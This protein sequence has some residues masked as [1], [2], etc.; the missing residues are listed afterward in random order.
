MLKLELLSHF[1]AYYNV[2][3]CPRIEGKMFKTY[4]S[5]ASPI[6]GL[7]LKIQRNQSSKKR[8]GYKEFY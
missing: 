8:K 6:Q 1:F 7:Y 2:K 5:F 4:M 3:I